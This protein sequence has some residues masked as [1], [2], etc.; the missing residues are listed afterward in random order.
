[1][2]VANSRRIQAETEIEP[3]RV[4]LLQYLNRFGL[5][6]SLNED[7]GQLL[8]SV[9][10]GATS[11]NKTLLQLNQPVPGLALPRLRHLPVN[12]AVLRVHR[13]TARPAQIETRLL[14]REACAHVHQEY[15]N[16]QRYRQTS[17]KHEARFRNPNPNPPAT[18]RSARDAR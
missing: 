15:R 6:A 16:K 7:I 4:H 18:R 11:P 3:A 5:T 12:A 1:M 8:P 14:E 13:R 17:R 2:L 10:D 9:F